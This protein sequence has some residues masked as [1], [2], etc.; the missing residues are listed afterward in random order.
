M[1]AHKFSMIMRYTGLICFVIFGYIAYRADVPVTQLT[2][3]LLASIS[4]TFG[5]FFSVR[6]EKFKTHLKRYIANAIL[7]TVSVSVALLASFSTIYPDC[8]NTSL[9]SVGSIVA[10][11]CAL[12]PGYLLFKK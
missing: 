11:L 7:C 2:L 10:F 1:I 8:I 5:F 4:L 6:P 12:Y 3:V 9:F